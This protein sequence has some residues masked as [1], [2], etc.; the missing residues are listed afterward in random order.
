ML[1]GSVVGLDD[2]SYGEMVSHRVML[3]D[4]DGMEWSDNPEFKTGIATNG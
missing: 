1:W 4:W 3:L 2:E